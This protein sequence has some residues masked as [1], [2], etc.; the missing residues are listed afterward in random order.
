MNTPVVFQ[1]MAKK[2]FRELNFVS[3][4]VA[5]ASIRMATIYEDLELSLAIR[6]RAHTAGFQVGF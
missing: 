1:Q 2:M 3:F 6:K 5:D 4:G